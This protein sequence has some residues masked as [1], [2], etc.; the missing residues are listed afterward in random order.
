MTEGGIAEIDE[1]DDIAE[2]RKTISL[3]NTDC[4]DLR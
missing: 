2:S 4:T 3:I 1:I